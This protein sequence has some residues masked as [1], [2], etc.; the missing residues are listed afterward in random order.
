MQKIF[1]N[2]RFARDNPSEIIDGVPIILPEWLIVIGFVTFALWFFPQLTLP[3]CLLMSI[4]ALRGSRESLEM[5]IILGYLLILGRGDIALGRWLVLFVI[6]AKVVFDTFHFDKP[7]SGFIYPILSFFITIFI[8]SVMSSQFLSISLFKLIAFTMGIGSLFVLYGRTNTLT[9]YWF[10]LLFT[11]GIF[12]LFVSLP[13][14]ASSVGYRRNGVG[15][16]GILVHPQTYGPVAASFTAILT[17]LYLFRN[18]RSYLIIIGAILGWFGVFASQ[19]RTSFLAITL[20]MTMVYLFGFI[21]KPGRWK[22]KV[23]L[24]LSRPEFILIGIFVIIMATF[25]FESV[26]DSIQSFI[27]KSEDV[28]SLSEAALQS[29]GDLAD[30]SLENFLSSPLTGIGFGVPSN[31]EYF[32]PQ[33]GPLGIPISAPVEKGFMPSA[34]IEETGIIGSLAVMF[35]L[36]QLFKPV[37]KYGTPMLFWLLVTSLSVNFGEFIFFS[38]GGMGLYFWIVMGF[39]YSSTKFIQENNHRRNREDFMQQKLS[40]RIPVNQ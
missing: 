32:S 34:V 39:C 13:L 20:G 25:N 16:Q 37:L 3:V 11:L 27:F 29:R 10:S 19:A 40:K 22:E 7:L 18:S 31:Y 2:S 1:K 9:Y 21:M 28:T 23:K 15:F 4:Y 14:Y 8:I 26:Q 36:F 35:L 12:I 5:L 33:L 6:T 38:V 17:S 24:S 30:R